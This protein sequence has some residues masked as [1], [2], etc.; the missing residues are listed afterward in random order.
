MAPKYMTA[1]FEDQ[2]KM[3]HGHYSHAFYE[4][5]KRRQASELLL[6]CLTQVINSWVSK[7]VTEELRVPFLSG[8]FS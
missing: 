6:F 8:Y 3:C 1:L 7:D 5:E 4:N 2:T